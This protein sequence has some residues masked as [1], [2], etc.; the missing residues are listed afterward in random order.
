MDSSCQENA[1]KINNVKIVSNFH[2]VINNIFDHL[3]KL[4][5][6]TTITLNSSYHSNNF[7]INLKSILSTDELNIYKSKSQQF[8]H[9]SKLFL[10]REDKKSKNKIFIEK[11]GNNLENNN[12]IFSN[13]IKKNQGKKL[14]VKNKSQK[15]KFVNNKNKAS[16]KIN[17]ININKEINFG[18]IN[19]IISDTSKE[20]KNCVKI[21]GGDIKN[22]LNDKPPSIYQFYKQKIEFNN[23][24]VFSNLNDTL[25]NINNKIISH[26]L[27]NHL[28]VQNDKSKNKII[29]VS[30]TRRTKSK[31][32]LFTYYVKKKFC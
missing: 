2:I 6:S 13:K 18:A 21:K 17:V 25:G 14:I 24:N 22:K 29:S 28:M 30:I 4:G 27:L 20:K 8:K 11:N 1:N 15:N 7:D 9:N 10:I 32:V 31:R 12:L 5:E 16:N 26:P 3:N 23:I 19:N